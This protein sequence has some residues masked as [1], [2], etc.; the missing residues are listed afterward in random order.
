MVRLTRYRIMRGTGAVLLSVGVIATPVLGGA[1]PDGGALRKVQLDMLLSKDR[2]HPYY[3]ASF[4][5][6]GEWANLSGKR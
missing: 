4:I 3:W 2:Q 6:S 5:Q 1:R